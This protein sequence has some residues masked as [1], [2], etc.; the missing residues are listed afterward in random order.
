[1]KASD[2]APLHARANAPR[3]GAARGNRESRAASMPPLGFVPTALGSWLLFDVDGQVCAIESRQLR[4][5][6]LP[7]AIVALPGRGSAAWPGIMAWQQRPLAVL[8]CGAAMGLRPSLGGESSRVLVVHDAGQAWALLVDHV[9]GVHQQGPQCL[10]YVQ[11]GLPAPWNAVRALLPL[12]PE[13][14][15]DAC[16][17]LHAPTLVQGS[18]DGLR[19]RDMAGTPST[20]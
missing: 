11:P 4:Q 15:G 2:A 10:I 14:G 3:T 13:S 9:R 1:M 16:A 18:L 6:A 12:P 8:D 19:A 20:E 17:V 5:V 7:A